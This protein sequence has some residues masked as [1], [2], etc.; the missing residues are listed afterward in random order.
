MI[1]LALD[2]G[3]TES[4]WC[5]MD[6][7]TYTPYDFGKTPN[8]EVLNIVKM[9]D[10]DKLVY[11]EFKGYGMPIGDSTIRSITWNGRFIQSALDRGK[12]VGY[13]LRVEEKICLCNSTKAKD[14]NIRQALIDEFAQFDFKTGK[15]TKKKPDWFYNFSLDIWTGYAVGVTFIRLPTEEKEKRYGSF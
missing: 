10:Y 1:I 13:V 9:G 5:L 7:E 3:T 14:A 11:E 8:E 15:G 6:C 12:Q 2:V 4:G